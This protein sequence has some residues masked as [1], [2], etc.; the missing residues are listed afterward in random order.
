MLLL[1]AYVWS[2]RQTYGNSPSRYIAALLLCAV[3]DALMRAVRAGAYITLSVY[4][5]WRVK[6]KVCYRTPAQTVHVQGTAAK[7]TG[8]LL[9]IDPC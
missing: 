1:Q 9:S 5:M 7:P 6:R 2:S 8:V 3:T 4:T